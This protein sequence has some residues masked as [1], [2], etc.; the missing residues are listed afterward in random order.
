[1][2]N[3]AEPSL[4]EVETMP[5]W[6]VAPAPEPAEWVVGPEQPEEEEDDLV[7]IL[8]RCGCGGSSDDDPDQ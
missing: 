7:R 5:D 6:V 1:M 4:P 2:F 3:Q 8:R